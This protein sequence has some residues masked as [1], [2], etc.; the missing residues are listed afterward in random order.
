M[1]VMIRGSGIAAGHGVDKGY[2]DIIREAL[3]EIEV[4]NQSR[5]GD[6]SFHGVRTFYEDIDPYRPD[7]L[8]VHFGI[9]DAYQGVYRSEFKENLVRIIQLA[10]SR[11]HPVI[12][13]LTSHLFENHDESHM[14]EGYYRAIREVAADLSCTWVPVHAY[15]IGKIEEKGPPVSSYLQNDWRYPNERGHELYA[16]AVLNRI[17]PLVQK[18]K[19]GESN[20]GSH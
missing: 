13:L 20:V 8:L 15:W 10:R 5:Y 2:V 9:D 11:F 14:I 18:T 6:T 16:E 17:C 12:A 19:K 3:P 7:I 4:R 1:K